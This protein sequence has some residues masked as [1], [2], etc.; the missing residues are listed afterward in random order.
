MMKEYEIRK[1]LAEILELSIEEVLK[2]GYKENLR[3]YSLNSLNSIQL[4]VR[5]EEIIGKE[6][7]NADLLLEHW[8]TIQK[9]EILMKKYV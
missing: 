8:D 9:I 2:I 1:V 6:I 7:D 5:I 3:G 4:V